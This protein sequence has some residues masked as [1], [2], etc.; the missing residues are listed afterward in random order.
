MRYVGNQPFKCLRRWF[1]QF[2]ACLVYAA[3]FLAIPVAGFWLYG[4]WVLEEPGVLSIVLFLLCAAAVV[5]FGW[6][7][8]LRNIKEGF[9][10]RIVPYF[11]S[12]V[13]TYPDS[14]PDAFSTGVHLARRCRFLD[15]RAVEAGVSPLS[16]FGFRDDRDWQQ[17]I[18]HPASA[19]LR[20]VEAL[21]AATGE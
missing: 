11:E 17:L 1:G 4:E 15:E 6:Y 18:W 10:C 3:L 16:S 19:G 14:Q 20:T 2:V 21:I 8:L 12:R 5:L 13:A 7:G 9:V